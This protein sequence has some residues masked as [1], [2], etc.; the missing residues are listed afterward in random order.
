MIRKRKR[1]VAA[2]NSDSMSVLR[3][4]SSGPGSGSVHETSLRLRSTSGAVDRASP[5]A[6]GTRKLGRRKVT[7]RTPA[8]SSTS[9]PVPV[10]EE[11]NDKNREP[12]RPEGVAA[13][14]PGGATAT[15]AT[16]S[17]TAAVAAPAASSR[18]SR[19]RKVVRRQKIKSSEAL[20]A[21]A[22]ASTRA[23]AGLERAPAR[24]ASTAVNPRG[25]PRPASQGETLLAAL[26][27]RG[28][29]VAEVTLR[30]ELD[31]AAD[32]PDEALSVALVHCAG[33]GLVSCCRLLLDRGAPLNRPAPGT[34]LT[35]LQVAASKGQVAVC[36]EF[37]LMGA[38]P[39]GVAE[40]ALR[41]IGCYGPLFA[42]ELEAIRALAKG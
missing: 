26:I 4:G 32:W 2:L 36:R 33:R 35:P 1:V 41:G 38:N 22:V 40:A 12:S 29:E 28:A 23:E 31:A 6:G 34:R 20:V 19:K 18:R 8:S 11:S 27:F 7:Q 3:S 9:H 5:A 37:I 39:V 21:K 17:A 14:D 24:S 25:A 42:A 30:N 10:T 15:S 16:S 13:S